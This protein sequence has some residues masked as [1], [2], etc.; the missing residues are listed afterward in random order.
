MCGKT[1]SD[2]FRGVGAALMALRP[3]GYGPTAERLPIRE[4]N[5]P[6]FNGNARSSF[7]FRVSEFVFRVSGLGFRVS[8]D[9]LE[10][11]GAA[12]VA[13]QRPHDLETPNPQLYTL[14]TIYI[15]IHI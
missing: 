2:L 15:Y 9:L 4:E 12:L 3:N 5:I 8:T 14:S 7:G 11:A 1:G 13:L 10:G 6:I